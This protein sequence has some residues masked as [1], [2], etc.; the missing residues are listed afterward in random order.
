[1]SSFTIHLTTLSLIVFVA[2]LYT[3]KRSLEKPQQLKLIIQQEY[4]PVQSKESKWKDVGMPFTT[5][6][7][8]DISLQMANGST[9]KGAGAPLAA[10]GTEKEKEE[11]EE[12][13]EVDVDV[14]GEDDE[15]VPFAVGRTEEGC[16]VFS[17]KWVYDKASMPHYAEKECRYI[18]PQFKCEAFGRPDRAYQFWRWQPH[19]CSLQRFN[20]TFMLERLRGKRILFVGDSLSGG[21][22]FSM[23]CL[24]DRHIARFRKGHKHSPSLTIF[25][26]PEYNVTIEF[27]WAPF[28]IE[29]NCD[30]STN[31][32]VKERVIHL[33]PGSIEKHAEDW[34][35]A[36]VLVF[37]TYTWWLTGTNMKTLRGASRDGAKFIKEMELEKAYRLVLKRMVRWLERNLDPLKT[38]VF[39]TSMSP[40]HFRSIDWGGDRQGNCYGQR[41]PI[42]DPTYW[43]SASKK[44]VMQV[45]S[46]VLGKTKLPI[47]VLNITQLSE[48][49][50]DAH[51]SIYKQQRYP[52]TNQQRRNPRSYADCVHW[53]LPGL[54]DTWNELFY[55]KLFFP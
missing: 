30:N 54:Q 7:A 25:A 29:S 43:G 18:N 21:Q 55:N 37:N 35:G 17:G 40:T 23:V 53:C 38:R 44:S 6:I 26:A 5:E 11:E 20:A 22:F 8:N 14:D 49:R 42:F 19:R 4:V 2:I 41:M 32:R 9:T 33:Y 36:D 1:M 31:H 12:E 16:D 46:E 47:T 15:Y 28:L 34:K 52:L 51:T 45:V 10:G 50:R 48:Y 24:L 13:E 3:E 27:Y 39:F